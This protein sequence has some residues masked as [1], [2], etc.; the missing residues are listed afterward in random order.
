MRREWVVF[1]TSLAFA[2]GLADAVGAAKIFKWVDEK[3]VTHYGETIPTEYKDQ[4]ATE[5]SKHGITCAN[6]MRPATGS[7]PERKAAEEKAAQRARRESSAPSSSAG[8]T[9]RW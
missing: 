9:W 1:L 5:M 2:F 4:A 3:G 6:S 8:A 7:R